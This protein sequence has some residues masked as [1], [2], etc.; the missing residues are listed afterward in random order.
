MALSFSFVPSS[1]YC[2]RLS[3]I[4]V[5]N[6]L[7]IINWHKAVG[8]FAAIIIATVVPCLLCSVFNFIKIFFW[9]MQ[10]KVQKTKRELSAASV[11]CL[12][13]P[14]HVVCLILF[15]VFL[16]SWIP[17]SVDMFGHLSELQVP[18]FYSFWLGGSQGIWKFPIMITFCPRYRE[19]FSSMSVNKH[20][21]AMSSSP[22]NERVFN[23]ECN[24]QPFSN[25]TRT[26]TEDI[27]LHLWK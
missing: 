10:W 5:D 20:T 18:S 4:L 2:A 11:E 22:T 26:G 3:T 25:Q 15:L 23:I 17:F 13:E 8:Y 1:L 24:A 16:I 9:Q 6:H 19:Y 27:E 7:C 21:D 14:T 12:L